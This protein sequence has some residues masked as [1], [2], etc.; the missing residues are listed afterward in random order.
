VPRGSAPSVSISI[1]HYETPD[2]LVRCLTALRESEGIGSWEVRV[3]DNGSRGFDPRTYASI[4]PNLEIIQNAENRGFAVASNQGLRS[5][6]GRYVL[7]LNPDAI[8]EPHA[9]AAVV[10]YLDSHPDVGCATARLVMPDGRLDLACRRSFPTP[11]VAF[12]RMT[13]LSRVF[14]RS[15]RFGR[16]N[17]SYL[18]DTLECEIDAPC[19]AFMMVRSSVVEEIGLLDE[20]YFMYGED[21]DWAFRIKAAGWRIVYLPSAVVHHV[22]RASSSRNRER[23]IRWFHESMRRFYNAHYRQAYPRGVTSAVM[24]AIGLRERIE[25]TSSRLSRTILGR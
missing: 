19:G 2:L 18:P 13:M 8:V 5:A 16:Y 6:G 22:K 14:P 21:L 9:I 7:L 3:V 23:T 17:L 20:A 1:V 10:E 24:F 15:R 25:L 4:L 12:F 11:A